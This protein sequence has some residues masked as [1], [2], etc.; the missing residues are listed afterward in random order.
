MNLLQQLAN[1]LREVLLN[2]TWIANTNFQDQ[3]SSVTFNQAVQQIDSLNTIA[4]FTYHINYF[5]EGLIHFFE[6]RRLD[7]RDKYS[8]DM[9]QLHSNA[10]WEEM[11]N[12]LSQNAEEFAQWVEQMSD[13]QINTNFVKDEYGTYARNVD[14]IIEH[15]YYDLGQ[16]SLIKK[17]AQSQNT[18]I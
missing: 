5:I 2:G 16:I 6:N 7:I 10:E 3:L 8:F 14:A 12:K 13:D 17:M 1:R 15:S 9:P 18:A 4:L 11:K